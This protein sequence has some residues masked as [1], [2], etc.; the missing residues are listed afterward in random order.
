MYHA[1]VYKWFNIS[2]LAACLLYLVCNIIYGIT[3]SPESPADA[4]IFFV[5]MALS[6]TALIV[7]AYKNSPKKTKPYWW[8]FICLAIQQV[9]KFI[10][11][12]FYEEMKTDYIILLL[13]VI[14][15]IY[16]IRKNARQ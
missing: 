9:V 6:M 5:P 3:D 2:A 8:A 14:G 4:R 15:L 12:N 11:F 7:V 16:K 1:P 10:G 13:I